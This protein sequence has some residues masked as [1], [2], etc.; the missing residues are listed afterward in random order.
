MRPTTLAVLLSL[1]LLAACGGDDSAP[2]SFDAGVEESTNLPEPAA[3]P[4]VADQPNT[5]PLTTEDIDRWRRGMAAEL[6]AVAAAEADLARSTT[7][8]DTLNAMTAANDMST[9]GA[10]ARAAGVSEDRYRF[11]RR[12]L[13]SA[14]GYLSPIEQEMDVS[15]MPAQMVE[16]FEQGRTANL[17]R[18]GDALPA[19]V[20][21]ALRPQ[22]AELRQ[23]D[24]NLT[25]A[26]LRAAGAAR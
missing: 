25:A 13:S 20:I 12:T 22:A 10:G 5:A 8:E 26:R 9:L 15:Q 17:E 19:D 4:Q 3:A 21:E 16:Q 7:S 11:I 2:E 14:A 23:Q 6:E 1:V 18:L 24:R